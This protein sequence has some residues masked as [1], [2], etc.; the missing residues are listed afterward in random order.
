MKNLG[1]IG[2][3]TFLRLCWR[4]TPEIAWRSGSRLT[5]PTRMQGQAHKVGVT[6]LATRSL[7]Q[8]GVNAHQIDRNGAQDMLYLRFVQAI[9]ACTSYPHPADR[10]GKRPFDACSSLIRLSKRGCLLFLSPRLQG[11]MRGLWTHM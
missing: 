3:L 11:F 4:M 7:G 6:G 2:F 8:N 5:L 10:L 9:I 1:I